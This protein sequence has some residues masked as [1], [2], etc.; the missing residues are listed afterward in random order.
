VAG[1]NF[2]FKQNYEDP[3]KLTE[4]ADM[5]ELGLEHSM[6]EFKG[7]TDLNIDIGAVGNSP[8]VHLPPISGTDQQSS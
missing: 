2:F 8:G 4:L 6:D 3:K 7:M 1:D 5:K